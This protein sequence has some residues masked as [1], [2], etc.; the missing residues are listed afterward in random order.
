MKG[1]SLVNG[2]IIAIFG[3]MS[4]TQEGFVPTFPQLTIC[5]ELGI[6]ADMWLQG[7]GSFLLN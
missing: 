3:Y 5:Y 1:K 7:E 2:I 4:F 6:Q